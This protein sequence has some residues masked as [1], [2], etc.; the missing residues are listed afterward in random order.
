MQG[1]GNQEREI[2]VKSVGVWRNLA[3]RSVW[4]RENSGSNPGIPTNFWKVL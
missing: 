1:Q 3:S 2:I 4:G